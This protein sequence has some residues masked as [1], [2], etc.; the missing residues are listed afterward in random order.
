VS[1]AAS[2]E[3]AVRVVGAGIDPD[4]D[5]VVRRV[6]AGADELALMRR[7]ALVTGG[8]AVEALVREALS[9]FDEIP[10]TTVSE[11]S[12]TAVS[13][14]FFDKRKGLQR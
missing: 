11:K 6:Y 9:R 5:C 12:D 13:S 10:L 2:L 4:R 1:G 14:D 3:I 8:L 7:R